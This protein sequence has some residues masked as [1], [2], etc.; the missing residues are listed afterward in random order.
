MQFQHTK[1]E[2]LQQHYKITIPGNVILQKVQERLL[3]ISQRTRVDGFR[4]GHAPFELVTQR[5]EASV[6]SET[7]EDSIREALKV[8][9]K[10]H[11]LQR[12]NAPKISLDE[13]DK[14]KELVA[15]AVFEVMPSVE[16]KD[17][18][19]ISLEKPVVKIP[20]K[21]IEKVL[22]DLAQN[23]QSF[24][25]LSK[26][27]PVKEGDSV[28][29]QLVMNLEEPPAKKPGKKAP[30]PKPF[31]DTVIAGPQ[32]TH[33]DDLNKGLISASIGE[34][35]S[36]NYEFPPLKKKKATPQKVLVK[37]KVLEI[38]EPKKSTVDE[39]L[40][41]ELGFENLTLLREEAKAKLET[42][43]AQ[44]SR[45]YVKRRLLDSLSEHYS[46]DIPSELVT[47]EFNAIWHRLQAELEAAKSRGEEIEDEDKSEEEI[48]QE[49]QK[50]AERRVRLGLV[51]SAISE[52]NKI[53]LTQEEIRKA[54]IDEAVRHPGQEK[55]YL[56]YYRNTRGAVD[57]LAAPLLEDKV[58][59]F[60]L[61]KIT[62]QEKHFDIPGFKTLID[63]VIPVD[64]SHEDDETEG[65]HA[66]KKASKS[67]EK[68]PEKVE[69]KAEGKE[70]SSKAAT[71]ETK[72]DASPEKK[73]PAGEKKA[74]EGKGKK[75][76]T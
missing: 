31:V 12:A 11:N 40:A 7:I 65:Q 34:E 10:E 25:A 24:K 20:E 15:T 51:I 45:L 41:K 44:L 17:F 16:I 3:Q 21:R 74:A 58:V 9:V 50:I 32:A 26:D 37:W 71:A 23:H 60:I 5:Y 28:K 52:E 38:K 61:S 13:F 76:T 47:G 49:Y 67:V 35:K 70:K 33:F 59:D 18:S 62:L 72:E 36:F 66:E 69:A 68:T 43:F 57:Q 63:G 14:E 73:K 6:L 39:E 29:I 22:E 19:G 42:Q 48:R 54:V 27:R 75:A 53:H 56:D 55:A 64:L 4:V 8:L 2:G 46:F 30:A 1:T